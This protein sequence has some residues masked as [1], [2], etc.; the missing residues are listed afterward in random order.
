MDDQ[1][2]PIRHFE[3]MARL[4]AAL[5]GLP[6]QVLDH[7]YHY[8]SFGSWAVTIRYQ[9]RPLRLTFDGK[10]RAYRIEESATR[11]APYSWNATWHAVESSADPWPAVIE[12]IRGR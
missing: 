6:A 7:S 5:K 1:D 9:G 11:R 4:A 2:Y 8:E 12:A 3:E 10:E